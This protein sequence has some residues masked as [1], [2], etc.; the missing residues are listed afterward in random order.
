VKQLHI[1]KQNQQPSSCLSSSYPLQVMA[2]P[3]IPEP[4]K[5]QAQL[6]LLRVFADC[7]T[8]INDWATS[9]M[10]APAFETLHTALLELAPAISKS[11]LT[12]PDDLAQPKCSK[13]AGKLMEAAAVQVG[14]RKQELSR[15]LE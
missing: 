1:I 6:Q 5:T 4:N 11:V 3:K 15:K 13:T 9:T 14:R 2:N 10:C 8:A 12:D 7:I